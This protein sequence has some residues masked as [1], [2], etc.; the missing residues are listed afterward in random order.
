MRKMISLILIG[1]VLIGLLSACGT[2]PTVSAAQDTSKPPVR[3]LN[4]IGSGKVTLVPNV[5]YI[6]IGVHTEAANVTEALSKNTEQAQKVAEAVKALGVESKDIQTT[7]FNVYPQ[8]IQGPNGEMQETRYI[9]DNTIYVTVRDLSKL[10]EMLNGVVQSGA[11][12]ITGIQ[13]DIA[14]REKAIED[15]RKGAIADARS[16]A[17]MMAQAAGVILGSVQ[18]LN[19]Y[20]SN[21]PIPMYDVKGG[22]GGSAAMNANVPVSAGQLIITAEANVIYEIK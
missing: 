16:Q 14:D 5:A 11:N 22:T 13:F 12:N 21:A 9:V 2:I 7:A 1:F 20:S 15:A 10:G 18:T 17:E 19:V 4:V 6:N 8:Q 3:T